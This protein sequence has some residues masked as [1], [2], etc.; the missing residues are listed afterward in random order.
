MNRPKKQK[1]A[2][3]ST[4][5][6][7]YIMEVTSTKKE[8]PKRTEPAPEAPPPQAI[9]VRCQEEADDSK[10]A[11]LK[12]A[13]EELTHAKYELKIQTRRWEKTRRKYFAQGQDARYSPF[14]QPSVVDRVMQR[15][16]EADNAMEDADAYFVFCKRHVSLLNTLVKFKKLHEQQPDN[17]EFLEFNVMATRRLMHFYELQDKLQNEDALS[18]ELCVLSLVSKKP[19][20]AMTWGVGWL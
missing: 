13:R 12:C 6:V 5:L 7:E 9:C 19:S 1:V 20:L 14:D 8:A 3:S 4:R 11:K 15:L 17:I 10:L 2:F 18:K 16:Q